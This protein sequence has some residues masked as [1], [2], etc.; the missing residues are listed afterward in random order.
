MNIAYSFTAKFE[1]FVL[2]LLNKIFTLLKHLPKARS[3]KQSIV[4]TLRNTLP[5]LFLALFSEI[6]D[7]ALENIATSIRNNILIKVVKAAGYICNSLY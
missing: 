7:I 5:L 6:F 2:N 1:K 4:F 3:A